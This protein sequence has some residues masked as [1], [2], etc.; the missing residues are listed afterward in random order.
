MSPNAGSWAGQVSVRMGQSDLWDLMWRPH[1]QARW[2]GPEARVDFDPLVRSVLADEAGVWRTARVLKYKVSSSVTL[3]IDALASWQKSAATRSVIAL[4]TEEWNDGTLVTIEESGIPDGRSDEV[5]RFWR[6]RLQ[7]LAGLVGRVRARRG[8][9]RQ[10]VVVIHGIGEQQPGETLNGLVKSGVLS[11]EGGTQDRWVKPD[12]FSDS[13][14]L[15]RIT[16]E[17][18]AQRPTTDVFEFYWADVIRDTTLG[19]IGAWAERLLFRW[20]VP[21][22]ILPLWLLIWTVLL[23]TLGATGASLYGVRFADRVA[24]WSMLVAVAAAAWR[25][26]GEPMVLNFIGDAAR[27]LRPHPANIAH[28]QTIRQRGVQLLDKLHESGRYDRIVVLGHSLGSV[29][30]YDI[31]THLWIRFHTLHQNPSRS[32]FAAIMA[33]ER[34]LVDGTD[35]SRIQDLQHEAWRRQR[36]NTQP[37]LVTDLVTVGSPLTYAEFLLGK[38]AEAFAQAKADRV[39]PTCPPTTEVEAA[40]KHRRMTHDVPYP[41]PLRSGKRTFVQFHHAAPFAVTRW[42]NLYFTT[43]HLGLAGDLIGGPVAGQ[44]GSWIKDVPL[45]SPRH[46]FTHTWYWRVIDEVDAHRTALREALCLDVRQSL[47]ELL[48]EMPAFALVEADARR[49]DEP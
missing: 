30:A 47:L 24:H 27:Y 48:K 16:L 35:P 2:L 32:S 36:I 11:A 23:I 37:W 45:T 4:T 6:T 49:K 12:R 17:A 42:T 13:Y 40:T 29:I 44:L 20:P 19:Q 7:R 46:R 25:F 41:D 18:T 28:R 38:D 5:E 14:E 22:P 3:E 39:L 1:G 21:P 33:L 26:L 15:R 9:V 8:D 43:R 10:A 31:V 34:A